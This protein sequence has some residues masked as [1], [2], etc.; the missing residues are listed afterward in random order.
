MKK[1][2]IKTLLPYYLVILLLFLVDRSLKFLALNFTYPQS[3][4]KG[5]F[6][7]KKN[8]GIAFNFNLPFV[9]SEAQGFVIYLLVI[10]I[11]I[12]L[13]SINVKYLNEKKYQFHFLTLLIVV[14]ASSNLLD[15]LRF[16]FVIDYINLKFWPVFNLADVMI[17][18]GVGLWLWGLSR[19]FQASQKSKI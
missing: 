2:Q 13:I 8:T 12:F 5:L 16:G 14:G 4:F 11:L 7:F 9:P 17:V 19:K 18:A 3:M 1:I 15:R 10:V 6:I